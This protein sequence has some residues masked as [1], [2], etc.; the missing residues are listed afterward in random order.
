MVRNSCKVVAAN[1][2]VCSNQITI[3]G[4]EALGEFL[5]EN[6]SITALDLSA[7]RIDSMGGLAV[8]NSL[9]TNS[10]LKML[11]VTSNNM[12]D[13]TLCEFA[14][15]LLKHNTS[16]VKIAVLN[17]KFN[18][19]SIQAF[20]QL[21]NT[22]KNVDLDI[23][24]YITD[25]TYYV[26]VKNTK[27]VSNPLLNSNTD[28]RILE[29]LEKYNDENAQQLLQFDANLIN[30]VGTFLPEQV[31]QAPKP[32]TPAAYSVASNDRDIE[33]VYDEQLKLI[34]EQAQQDN[35]I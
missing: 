13:A 12:N 33:N 25:A 31:V 17:N 2:G 32:E 22:R 29:V 4:G 7:N 34:L 10:T 6:T 24:P 5:K 20:Y 28:D 21:A 3:P 1:T 26:A 30:S 19:K 9:K 11:D 15:V 16:L 23:V 35:Q 14:T 27:P 8:A 18:Q